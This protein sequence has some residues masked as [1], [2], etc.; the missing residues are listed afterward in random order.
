MWSC[1]LS[2][3]KTPISNHILKQF[4]VLPEGYVRYSF[5]KNGTSFI[6]KKRTPVF[7]DILKE[8]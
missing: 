2:T 7:N 8:T 1:L 5:Y 6:I 4:K 3:Y